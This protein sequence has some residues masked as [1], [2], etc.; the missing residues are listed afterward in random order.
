[1]PYLD[2]RENTG[3][4]IPLVLIVYILTF[5]TFILIKSPFCCTVV[6]KRTFERLLT[7][8]CSCSYAFDNIFLTGQIKYNDR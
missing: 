2:G 3:I 8:D 5:Y 1:M 7:F 4:R 6:T